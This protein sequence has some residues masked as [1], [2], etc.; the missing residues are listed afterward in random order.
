MLALASTVQVSL[1][2][3]ADQVVLTCQQHIHALLLTREG[4]VGNLVVF[5]GADTCS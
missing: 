2:H 3:A 5:E 1:Q 4:I